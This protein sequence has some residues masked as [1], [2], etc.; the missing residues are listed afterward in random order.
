MLR[1]NVKNE[2]VVV[3]VSEI[4]GVSCFLMCLVIAH[5]RSGGLIIYSWPYIITFCT[6]KI[7]FV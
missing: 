2:S 5:G 4:G 3:T 1:L 7:L 6:E